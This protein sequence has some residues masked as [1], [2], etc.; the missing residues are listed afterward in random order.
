MAANVRGGGPL[1]AI[2]VQRRPSHDHVSADT[3]LSLA[4]PKT[5]TR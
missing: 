1:T 5:R 3:A 2:R 4:P